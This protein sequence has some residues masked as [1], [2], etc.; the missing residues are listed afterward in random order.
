ML[1]TLVDD[2]GSAIS[3]SA[4]VRSE[5]NFDALKKMGV[6]PIYFN[7]LHDLETIKRVASEH[8]GE[9]NKFIFL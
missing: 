8:Q 5:A 6:H 2:F 4:L 3:L 1:Q 9:W 7:G